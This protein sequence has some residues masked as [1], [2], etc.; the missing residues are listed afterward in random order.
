MIERFQLFASCWPIRVF[1]VVA[2]DRSTFDGLEAQICAVIGER[3]EAALLFSTEN[4][5]GRSLY[6]EIDGCQRCAFNTRLTFKK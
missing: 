6:V 5:P 3:V 1:V 4:E 2:M